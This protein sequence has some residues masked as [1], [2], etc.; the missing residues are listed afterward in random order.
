MGLAKNRK[1]FTSTE[2]ERERDIRSGIKIQR[3]GYLDWKTIS[4]VKEDAG[5]AGKFEIGT[6]LSQMLRSCMEQKGR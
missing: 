1:F 2:R 5:L 3:L 6:R 4:Q